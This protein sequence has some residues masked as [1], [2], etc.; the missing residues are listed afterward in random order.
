MTFGKYFNQSLKEGDIPNSVT[1]LTFGDYF[2]QPLK[3]CDIP[4][5]VTHLTFGNDFNQ[6][7]N[8][9]VIPDS[10]TYLTVGWK[11]LLLLKDCLKQLNNIIQI[12]TPNNLLIKDIKTIKL[13]NNVYIE[14]N[15]NY[16]IN[17]YYDYYYIIDYTYITEHMKK[18]AEIKYL[19][20]IGSEYFETKN[21]F[22]K[23]II[24]N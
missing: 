18:I 14:L 5:Y 3:K 2:N 9:G 23:R 17:I 10:V 15:Q 8:N 7:L 12:N 4:N 19:P 16:I 24:K 6:L 11:Y 22:E 21:N 13:L 20:G 1:H